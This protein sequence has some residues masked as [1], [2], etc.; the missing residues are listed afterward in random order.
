MFAAPFVDGV[1]L[2]KEALFKTL[3]NRLVQVRL[4]DQMLVL[5]GCYVLLF[6]SSMPVLLP[7]S[8]FGL[9]S[10]PNVF[11]SML[12]S[13]SVVGIVVRTVAFPISLHAV[14]PLF[15]SELFLAVMQD[16]SP[17]L[18][19]KMRT[20]P[21]DSTPMRVWLP[22]HLARALPLLLLGS[23]LWIATKFPLVGPLFAALGNFAV[24]K[25][26]IGDTKAAALA[27]LAIFVTGALGASLFKVFLT[28]RS[29]GAEQCDLYLY[30]VLEAD[31]PSVDASN[32]SN[33]AMRQRYKNVLSKRRQFYK[34]NLA[35]VVGFALPFAMVLLFVPLGFAIYVVAMGAAAVLANH[36]HV[37]SNRDEVR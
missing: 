11:W 13:T 21:S 24:A 33:A 16:V 7:L 17:T 19:D 30:R 1:L 23:V 2:S 35:F 28:A 5:I 31:L 36:I 25:S 20:Q 18:F 9:V 8:M 10:V 4:R 15:A 32:A 22:V 29:L 14:S 12:S 34:H 6:V 3:S 27:A 37:S 26:V